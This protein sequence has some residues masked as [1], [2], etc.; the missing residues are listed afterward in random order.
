[1]K[2]ATAA[3]G[4]LVLLV[5]ASGADAHQRSLSFSSWEIHGR[6]AE[7][8]L[9]VTELDLSRLPPEASESSA[10][11]F[12]SYLQARLELLAGDGRCVPEG[13]A[14]SRRT[15]RGELSFLWRVRCAGE[16]SLRVRSRLFEE[17]SSTHLHFA[18]VRHDR[19]VEERVL[20]E[21]AREWLLESAGATGSSIG[22]YV[23]LGVEHIVTGYDHLA[24]LL[25]LL[26]VSQTLGA[27][28]KVVTGFT[29]AHSLTL[30]LATTGLVRPDAAPVEALIGLSIAIVALE[31]LWLGGERRMSVPAVTAAVL[32]V[33]GGSSF[34]GIGNVPGLTLFG[35]ALFVPS[36]FAL[37]DR[38]S[39]STRLRGAIAFLFGLLH[40]FGFAGVLIDAGLPRDRLVRALFGFNLGVELGQL[41]IVAILWLLFVR[42]SQTR[43]TLV[44]EYGSASVLG[45]GTFWFLTRALG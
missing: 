36:Y 24:F 5:F 37:L 13:E 40:G 31:N 3:A 34:A 6:E 26:V 9:R 38:I 1:V 22:E 2:P 42:L 45:L 7:V 19:I 14:Q 30:A 20:S 15:E 4:F 21:G 33:M 25:A 41:A 10:T 43:R 44:V 28:A 11:P 39:R 32:L 17:S 29:L 23:R 27:V 8:R 18:R 12:A 35:F 16:G